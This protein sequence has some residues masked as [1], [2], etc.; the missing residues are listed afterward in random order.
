M[1]TA[2]KGMG[3]SE[4]DWDLSVMHLTASLDKFKVG[5]TEKNEL[6]AAVSTFKKDIVEMK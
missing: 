3:I 5:A 1:K 6:L 2:H 4:A